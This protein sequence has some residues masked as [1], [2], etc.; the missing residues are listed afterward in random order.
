MLTILINQQLIYNK[1]NILKKF[2]E[3]L[4]SIPKIVKVYKFMKFFLINLLYKKMI[5][6]FKIRKIKKEIS[7]KLNNKFNNILNKGL[8]V[9]I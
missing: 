9:F 6:N 3:D 1:F 8:I 7:N 2:K 5:S 4:Q